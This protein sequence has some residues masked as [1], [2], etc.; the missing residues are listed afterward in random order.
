MDYANIVKCY[1]IKDEKILENLFCKEEKKQHLHFTKKYASRYPG[2]DLRLNEGI[3]IN[4]ILESKDGKRISGYTVQG[5]C[6]F[7]S[8]ELVVFIGSKQEEQNLDNRNFR[9]YLN[10]L[11]KLGIY[12]P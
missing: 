8:S 2:E 6:S 12:K 9:Y 4:V 7:I 5:S 10:C 1:E 3:L 11:K